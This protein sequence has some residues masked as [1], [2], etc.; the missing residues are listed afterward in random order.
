MDY[1]YPVDISIDEDGRHM[2]LYPDYPEFATDG[3]TRDEALI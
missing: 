3:E 2:V 1:I